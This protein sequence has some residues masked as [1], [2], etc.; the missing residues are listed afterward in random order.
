MS[1]TSSKIC[2]TV[3]DNWNPDENV[4]ATETEAGVTGSVNCVIEEGCT[5]GTNGCVTSTE[6]CVTGTENCVT[7][8]EDCVT[9]TKGCVTGTEDCV[10]L[11]KGCVTEV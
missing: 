6:D 5:T 4:Y 3:V 7:G 9:V 10:T 11:F 1:A 2:E 8:A